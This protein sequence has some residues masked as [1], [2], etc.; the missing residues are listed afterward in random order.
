MT[1]PVRKAKVFMHNQWAGILEEWEA[2]RRYR[3]VYLDDYEGPPISLTMS[4]DQD[5]YDFSRFPAF[6]EGLL[7]EGEML[8]G[9]LR[10]HK[11]DQYD[12][13]AQLMAVGQELVGAT[14]VEE[15]L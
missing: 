13:F 10:Q 1:E 4:V 7:P 2:N 3:F 11:I 6:F 12:Y 5:V 9:L 14:T 15:I 8:E